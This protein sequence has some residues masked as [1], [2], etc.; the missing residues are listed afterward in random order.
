MLMI[1]IKIADSIFIVVFVVVLSI[2]LVLVAG[3]FYEREEGK[4]QRKK[5]KNELI[6]EP[7]YI[8]KEEQ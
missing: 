7:E 3:I 4:I 6:D 5:R 2:I 8:P 1:I